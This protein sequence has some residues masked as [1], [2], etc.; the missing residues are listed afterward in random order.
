MEKTGDVIVIILI[1]GG[2]VSW[3]IS[4][5]PDFNLTDN[6]LLASVFSVAEDADDIHQ[7]G[8]IAVSEDKD[9]ENFQP[10]NF[11]YEKSVDILDIEVSATDPNLIFAGSN[12]GLFISRNGGRDWYEFSDLEKK[13]ASAKIYKIL[14]APVKNKNE[15]FISIFNGGKGTVYKTNDNFFSVEEILKI[16]GEAVYDF[17]SVGD[18][19]YLGMSDGRIVAYSLTGREIQVLNNLKSPIKELRVENRGNLIYAT[20]KSGKLMKSEDGGKSFSR[21]NGDKTL[22]TALLRNQIIYASTNSGLVCSYDAGNSWEKIKTIPSDDSKIGA[23]A[24]GEKGEIFASSENKIIY[25]SRDSGSSWKILDPK[26]GK[27]KVSTITLNNDKI[28][29]G[30]KD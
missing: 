8:I 5:L 11:H 12:K 17:E 24:V 26:I 20:L 19:L 21:K 3:L 15:I 10:A 25:N 6:N 7:E 1:W 4:V 29:V 27:R 23:L 22:F 18:Y 30:S 16:D 2:L 28:I 13:L 9:K 14:T